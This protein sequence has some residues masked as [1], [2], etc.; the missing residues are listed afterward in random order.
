MF[1]SSKRHEFQLNK[2]ARTGNYSFKK[3]L[4]ALPNSFVFLFSPKN[5][6]KKRGH[7]GIPHRT[8]L[9]IIKIFSK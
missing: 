1:I 8:I 4:T 7:E 3:K 5:N 9:L 6:C 2:N